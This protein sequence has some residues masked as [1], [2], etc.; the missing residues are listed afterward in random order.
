MPRAFDGL[1]WAAVMWTPAHQPARPTAPP[2]TPCHCPPDPKHK[3]KAGSLSIPYPTDGGLEDSNLGDPLTFLCVLGKS[4]VL[5]EKVPFFKK[6]E[7]G[8][9]VSSEAS[10]PV[11]VEGVA[12]RSHRARLTVQLVLR[13]AGPTQVPQGEQGYRVG[14]GAPEGDSRQRS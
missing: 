8:A 13:E 12:R 2:R 1:R 14:A 10:L 11:P 5:R 4:H 9:Q 7:V 6:T 3:T